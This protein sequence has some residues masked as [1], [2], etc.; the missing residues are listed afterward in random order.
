MVRHTVKP[1]WVRWGL[2]AT[3]SLLTVSGGH[4]HIAAAQEQ[5]KE[6]AMCPEVQDL[7][8][9][10]NLPCLAA[11]ALQRE[12][13]TV[14]GGIGI[15]GFWGASLMAYNDRKRWERVNFAREQIK[16]FNEDPEVQLVLKLIDTNQCTTKLPGDDG[17]PYIISD[18]Q[19][20]MAM[21]LSRNNG[22]A[23]SQAEMSIRMAFDAFFE[24]LEHL[25]HL[26]ATGLVRRSDLQPYLHYW[27]DVLTGGRKRSIRAS[28]HSKA[29][30]A[31]AGAKSEEWRS[32]I[33]QFMEAYGYASVRKFI[34]D[35]GY[36]LPTPIARNQSR[37]RSDQIP[38]W[39]LRTL[40]FG[41][42]RLLNTGDQDLIRR[43][44]HLQN[45]HSLERATEG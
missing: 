14:I 29:T 13:T 31:A 15:L 37:V 6:V 38:E 45:Q 42:Y 24:H 34:E 25:S 4:Q 5:A 23:Y 30:M 32:S 17:H 10:K 22:G 35:Y 11:Q 27:L 2:M 28:R 7:R 39:D 33:F 18:A 9:L 41:I 21:E 19:V 40:D 12:F 3:I 44:H 20:I 26:I 16:A 36:V 8:V 43:L 1:G